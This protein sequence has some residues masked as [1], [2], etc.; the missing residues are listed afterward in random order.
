MFVETFRV[1]WIK[2]V[3][4][5]RDCPPLKKEKKNETTLGSSAQA[6]YYHPRLHFTVSRP[7]V[8]VVIITKRQNDPCGRSGRRTF[9]QG[10][11]CLPEC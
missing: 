7:H 3:C 6:A 10:G 8:V 4:P 1:K 9:T 5:N 11:L 2:N